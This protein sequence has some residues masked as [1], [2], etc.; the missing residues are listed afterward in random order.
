MIL[1]HKCRTPGSTEEDIKGRKA[2]EDYGLL[3]SYLFR[4]AE[5]SVLEGGKKCIFLPMKSSRQR[6][7]PLIP[8]HEM[9]CSCTVCHCREYRQEL[10]QKE[11][12]FRF[13]LGLSYFSW[14]LDSWDQLDFV[15]LV[16][17]LLESKRLKHGA[18]H[19][20]S[21]Q[22]RSW[23]CPQYDW[24]L[25]RKLSRLHNLSWGFRRPAYWQVAL[26]GRG[27]S[28]SRHS[29]YSIYPQIDEHACKDQILRGI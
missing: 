29:S 22:R 24:S 20:I 6:I 1:A 25:Q 26:L 17:E 23:W 7:Y 27:I 5:E 21:G 9:L 18:F 19:S 28:R 13:L 16:S 3:P 14:G 11:C 2:K 12:Y 10:L 8:M 4:F 15:I